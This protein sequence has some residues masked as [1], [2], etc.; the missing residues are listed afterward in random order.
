MEKLL[1]QKT[2]D[3]DYLKGAKCVIGAPINYSNKVIYLLII[4]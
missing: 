2:F 3:M 4:S 1:W